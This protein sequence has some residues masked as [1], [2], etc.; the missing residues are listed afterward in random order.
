MKDSQRGHVTGRFGG[1]V[2]RLTAFAVDAAL[3]VA[4]YGLVLNVV[5]FT[6]ELV[7]SWKVDRD[8]TETGAWLLLLVG[9]WLTYYWVSLAITGRTIGKWF[10]GLRVVERD[11]SPLRAWPA[12]VRVVTLPLSFV[13]FGL[14]FIGILIGD[15]RRALHDVLAG[16]VEVYDWGDRA[17]EI[18]APLTRWLKRQN[19]IELPDVSS[20]APLTNQG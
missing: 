6:L 20:D 1:P 18:P 17:A 2:T 9:W 3:S 16:S 10:V 19:V 13:F 11:G 4:L 7:F 8:D 15:E 14:G 5:L 12:F